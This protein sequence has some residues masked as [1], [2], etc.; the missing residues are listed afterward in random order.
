MEK[1]I[2]DLQDDILSMQDALAKV[3]TLSL[4]HSQIVTPMT[5]PELTP[6]KEPNLDQDEDEVST[7]SQTAEEREDAR[8]KKRVRR[9]GFSLGD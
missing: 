4:P 9:H 5:S 8:P 1:T 2:D 3:S 6:M 7:Y